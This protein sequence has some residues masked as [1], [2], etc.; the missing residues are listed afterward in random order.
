MRKLNFREVKLL[1][2]S[3]L[4][5]EKWTRFSNPGKP[6]SD[7]KVCFLVTILYTFLFFMLS[8]EITHYM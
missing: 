8:S 5:G 1:V 7:T 4:A 2:H 3:H 6:D